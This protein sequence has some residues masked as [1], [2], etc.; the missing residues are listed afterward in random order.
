MEVEDRHLIVMVDLI[1]SITDCDQPLDYL[2]KKFCPTEILYRLSQLILI[3]E[4]NMKSESP[5]LPFLR[6]QPNSDPNYCQTI[7]SIVK[8]WLLDFFRRDFVTLNRLEVE[9]GFEEELVLTTLMALRVMYRMR[10]MMDQRV[11]QILTN[12]W[13]DLQE[14]DQQLDEKF[15]KNCFKLMNL[16][17]KNLVNY[18]NQTNGL[19]KQIQDLNE[20]NKR[21]TDKLKAT[22]ENSDP[23]QS[24][25]NQLALKRITKKVDKQID[26]SVVPIVTKIDS[27]KSSKELTRNKINRETKTPLKLKSNL[28]KTSPISVTK[29]TENKSNNSVKNSDTSPQV[30]RLRSSPNVPSVKQMSPKKSIPLSPIRSTRTSPRKSKA[31]PK[32]MPQTIG[33][34]YF[35]KI[36]PLFIPISDEKRLLRNS[37]RVTKQMP[38]PIPLPPK[39]RKIKALS[40]SPV[41]S[42]IKVTVP[43]NVK[44]EDK[45]RKW[46]PSKSKNYPRKRR[47]PCDFKGCSYIADRPS[48]LVSDH[49]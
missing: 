7:G 41:T 3:Y 15:E 33:Q 11:Q 32:G 49:Q 4:T 18:N 17:V 44:P 31:S 46:W 25:L 26:S 45:P 28:P 30:Y 14:F 23:M 16:L 13:K 38:E 27:N 6:K 43:Q 35:E 9:T 20:E 47:Y 2:S 39:K 19:L 22:E 8:L 36:A 5:L 12:G 1:N 21:L 24:F 37:K 48:T 34:N 10:Q 40:Q 42:P 29:R